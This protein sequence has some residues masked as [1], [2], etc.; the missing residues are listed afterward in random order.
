MKSRRI[1]FL[2]IYLENVINIFSKTKSLRN[3]MTEQVHAAHCR[4]YCRVKA[5]PPS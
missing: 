1:I 2:L 5:D 4:S 3:D